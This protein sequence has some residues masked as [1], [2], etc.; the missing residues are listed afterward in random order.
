M[1]YV[2]SI[3]RDKPIDPAEVEALAAS[4]PT[5]ELEDED[6]IC[7]LHWANT[8][9]DKHESFVLSDGTLD[10]TSPSDA[11]LTVAQELAAELGARVIGEEGEDLSDVH[12]TGDPGASTGCG[13]LT[14]SILLIAALLA[15]YW[16]FN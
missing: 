1:S 5:F 6:G 3:V 11:A 2:V 14:G 4:S 8:S 12:V 9:T 10:I 7:I 16:F 13:P 15:A